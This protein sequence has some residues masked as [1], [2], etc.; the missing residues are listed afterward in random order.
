M[1]PATLTKAVLRAADLLGVTDELPEILGVDAELLAQARSGAAALQPE[2]PAWAIGVRFA[3]VYRALLTL[4]GDSAKA[5]AW[6]DTPH[7]TL[8]AVPRE[9]LRTEAGRERVFGYLDAVQ[10]YEI[11]L[12]PRSRH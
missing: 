3:G 12:P 2:S 5:R 11:K 6:L 10:K 1:N 7:S 4:A 8:G 9:L